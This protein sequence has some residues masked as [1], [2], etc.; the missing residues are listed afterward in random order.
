MENRVTVG[1]RIAGRIR[2]DFP[3][4]EVAALVVDLLEGWANAGPQREVDRVQAAIVL[5][6]AGDVDQ[7]EALVGLA[8]TDYRDALVST[9]FAHADWRARMEAAFR[10]K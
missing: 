7:V 8:H 5:S 1:A 4:P 6:A 2:R 3:E 9:G 10:A